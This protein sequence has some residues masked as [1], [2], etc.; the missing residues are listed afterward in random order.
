MQS[1]VNKLDLV[2]KLLITVSVQLRL[3]T[4]LIYKDVI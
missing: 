1:F 2:A 4:S 3:C